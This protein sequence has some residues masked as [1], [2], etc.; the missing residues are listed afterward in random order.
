MVVNT[1]KTGK[2][3]RPKTAVKGKRYRCA[4]C[5]KRSARPVT[6]PTPWNCPGCSNLA[7]TDDMSGIES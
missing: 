5:H 3:T 1:F 2:K 6:I 7:L 4:Q